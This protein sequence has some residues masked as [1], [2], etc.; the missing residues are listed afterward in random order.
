MTAAKLS[1]VRGAG[2]DRTADGYVLRMDRG[3]MLQTYLRYYLEPDG[4]LGHEVGALRPT[5]AFLC[6][7]VAMGTRKAAGKRPGSVRCVSYPTTGGCGAPIETRMAQAPRRLE[8]WC[9]KCGASGTI[10]GFE[11]TR[12]DRSK[13]AARPKAVRANKKRS[14]R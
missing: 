5:T 13:P 10:R 2:T 9:P 11:G 14:T 7:V 8:W 1:P 12:W 4:S 6:E 3:G